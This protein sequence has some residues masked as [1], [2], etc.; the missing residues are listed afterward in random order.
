MIGYSMGNKNIYIVIAFVACLLVVGYLGISHLILPTQKD[1]RAIEGADVVDSSRRFTKLTDQAIDL[2]NQ[3]N[4][5]LSVLTLNEAIQCA[6]GN[7][8]ISRSTPMTTAEKLLLAI[9]DQGIAE[10]DWS[11]I[12]IDELKSRDPDALMLA[13][14]TLRSVHIQS[15]SPVV[16]D[17]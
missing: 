8:I 11:K 10:P 7:G 13:K 4:V 14:A 6:K 12:S 17:P 5:E 15:E 1:A 2:L 3:N 16:S 9:L